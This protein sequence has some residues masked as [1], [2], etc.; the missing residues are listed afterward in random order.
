M[1]E[2]QTTDTKA[3]EYRAFVK[4]LF[5]S[6]KCIDTFHI[7]KELPVYNTQGELV[8][9]LT[10]ITSHYRKTI[11]DCA[12]MMGKWRAENPSASDSVFEITVE[13]TEK[14]LD[15]QIVGREDRLL[16]MVRLLDGTYIGHV[17]YSSFRFE[18]RA[19][20]IDAILRG[21]QGVCPG[22]MT[23]AIRT[24]LWWGTNILKL[25][26]IELSVGD[27]NARAQELYRRCGFVVKSKK[28]LVK[29]IKQDEVRWD[30][31]E[32]PDMPDAEKYAVIMTY[33]GGEQHE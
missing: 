4:D 2:K 5:D 24:L 15:Q 21:V 14:W 12:Y 29:V 22:I 3:Q 32:D 7:L 16:F 1:F 6:Y 31:A 30:P 13:R 25:D 10:P 19:A 9:Y 27:E 17:G 11:P 18:D 23:F 33:V 26:Q 8:A 20:E 28:A